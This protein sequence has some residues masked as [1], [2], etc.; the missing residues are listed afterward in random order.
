MFLMQITGDVGINIKRRVK[1]TK[2]LMFVFLDSRQL[3]KASFKIRELRIYFLK[4]TTSLRFRTMLLKFFCRRCS[5]NSPNVKHVKI[6]RELCAKEQTSV[7]LSALVNTGS[8]ELLKDTTGVNP[9][10][11]LQIARFLHREIPVRLAHRYTDLQQ[12]PSGLSETPSIEVVQGWYLSSIEDFLNLDI[13]K[14]V[15]EASQGSTFATKVE[16]IYERHNPTLV[17]VAKSLLELRQSNPEYDASTSA[18]SINETL[19][20]FYTARVG[21]RMLL[22]QYLSLLQ[23]K[24][25]KET[26]V[27]LIDTET[28]PASIARAAID[29][30]IFICE[31]EFGEAPE[32]DIVGR[33]D[34]AFPYVPSH[35]YYII[36]ELLKNSMRATIE[37]H[38]SL[39]LDLPPIKIVIADGEANDDV[40]IKISDEGGGILRRDV[41]KIWNYLYTTSRPAFSTDDNLLSN[42]KPHTKNVPLSGLGYGLP[43]YVFISISNLFFHTKF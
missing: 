27:G 24:S 29:D 6:I 14:N 20:D 8:G 17:T 33:T 30:A 11:L 12:L 18:Q 7:S 32:V 42:S 31:R 2:I 10:V 19:D 21:L 4:I 34:L 15:E 43:M 39:S 36:F 25:S 28:S 23:P 13:P 16:E 26:Y 9:L 40:C 1:Q 3:S 5:S 41:P 37:H 22:G 35:L 38:S